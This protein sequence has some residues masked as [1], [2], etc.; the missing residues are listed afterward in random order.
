[1]ADAWLSWLLEDNRRNAQHAGLVRGVQPGSSYTHSPAERA[2]KRLSAWAAAA[3]APR[4]R[5]N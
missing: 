2:E 1:M 3:A 4:H 5:W